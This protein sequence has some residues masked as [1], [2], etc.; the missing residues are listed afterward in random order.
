MTEREDDVHTGLPDCETANTAV[1]PAGE[2]L[3]GDVL[4]RVT[5]WAGLDSLITATFEAVEHAARSGRLM[6]YHVDRLEEL[7]R[8]ARARSRR[9]RK[10]ARAAQ[11]PEGEPCTPI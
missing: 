10:P 4:A 6:T 7:A 9:Q 3:A 2:A 11:D 5:A 1:R 8:D